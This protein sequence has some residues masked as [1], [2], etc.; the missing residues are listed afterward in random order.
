LRVRCLSVRDLA[1]AGLERLLEIELSSIVPSAAWKIQ[2]GGAHNCRE[3]K[4]LLS[5]FDIS[6]TQDWRPSYHGRI[7]GQ[8]PIVV[9][10]CSRALVFSC[11]AF[12]QIMILSIFAASHKA[13]SDCF[14]LPDTRLT[15][16]PPSHACNLWRLLQVELVRVRI[17]EFRATNFPD[18]I[19]KVSIHYSPS[20]ARLDRGREFLRQ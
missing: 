4:L 7:C 11:C 13:R 16:G 5:A 1:L 2:E 8:L 19:R 18:L 20:L 17:G 6:S 9:D 12:F 3:T 10:W 15:S 14:G